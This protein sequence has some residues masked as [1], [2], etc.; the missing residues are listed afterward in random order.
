MLIL[1]I[2]AGILLAAIV[3]LI[4]YSAYS[5]GEE[6]EGVT[7]GCLL[8]LVAVAALAGLAWLVV[9]RFLT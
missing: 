2:A 4:V 5:L 7:G 9:T 6:M 1:E 3:L 8:A